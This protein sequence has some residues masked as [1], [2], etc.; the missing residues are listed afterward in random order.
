[1]PYFGI[2]WKMDAHN[3]AE[4]LLEGLR[5]VE[6][7]G[8]QLRRDEPEILIRA[9]LQMMGSAKLLMIFSKSFFS[10]LAK[11]YCWASRL[12]TMCLY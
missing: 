1:M 12:L 6:E 4:L 9:G 2:I 10:R 8:Y 3:L 7:L 11:I 5:L